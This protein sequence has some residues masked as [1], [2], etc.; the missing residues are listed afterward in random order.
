MTTKEVIVNRRIKKAKKLMQNL[1][2]P[3]SEVAETSGFNSLQHFSK[4]FKKTEGTTAT[5]YRRQISE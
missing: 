4:T 1:D 3:L 2:I 5:Y